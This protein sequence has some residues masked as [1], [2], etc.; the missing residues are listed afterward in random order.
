MLSTKDYNP[1]QKY[2]HL[3]QNV[4][5]TTSPIFIRILQEVCLKVGGA[6]RLLL[7]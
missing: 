6:H 1:I 5:E 4:D 7:N 3:G 2:R